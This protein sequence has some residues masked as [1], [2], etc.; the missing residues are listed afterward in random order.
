MHGVSA[1]PLGREKEVIVK[2]V[3]FVAC[4]G[5]FAV[6]GLSGTTA[7]SADRPVENGSHQ[8]SAPDNRKS[9]FSLESS[10]PD[11]V[12]FRAT[13]EDGVAYLSGGCNNLLGP[14]LR[15]TLHAYRGDMLQKVDDES[16]DVVFKVLSSQH[17]DR[18]FS[19][20]MYYFAPESVWMT[21]DPLPGEFLEVL[22]QGDTLRVLNAGGGR[23]VNF[24]L[25]GIAPIV[26]AMQKVCR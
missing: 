1:I 6:P 19:G 17:G 14:G 4:I 12:A 10:D 15:F 2:S 20:R 9:A 24:D 5:L 16:E 18:S 21:T 26:Q 13:A 11:K 25:G 8:A 7:I 22:G 23:V 3:C